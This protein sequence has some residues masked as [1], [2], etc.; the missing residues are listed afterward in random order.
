MLECVRSTIAVQAEHQELS[1]QVI[2]ERNHHHHPYLMMVS[3]AEQVRERENSVFV[4]GNKQAGAKTQ[5][6]RYIA[7]HYL[8]KVNSV[9]TRLQLF[10]LCIYLKKV[11]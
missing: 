9:T 1:N 3:L 7:V 10:T 4:Y 8:K 5:W 11:L 6:V 2:N